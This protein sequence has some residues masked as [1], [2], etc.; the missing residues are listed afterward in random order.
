MN[1]VT[2]TPKRKLKYV[3]TINDETLGEDTHD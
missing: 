2:S 3:A 1:S